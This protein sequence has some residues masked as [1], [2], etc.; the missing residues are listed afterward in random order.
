MSFHPIRYICSGQLGD[1]V[2]A[3][4]V[5]NENYI[6]TGRKGIVYLTERLERFQY[7]FQKTYDALKSILHQQPYI[8][9]FKIYNNE[10]YDVDLSKWRYNITPQSTWYDIYSKTY[11]IE[12]GKNQWLY[13]PMIDKFKDSIIICH[14]IRRLNQKLDYKNFDKLIK[15]T[16]KKIYFITTDTREYLHF[17]KLTNFNCEYI[18]FDS[19]FDCW[20]AIASCYLFIGNMSSPLSVAYACHKNSVGILSA[21]NIDDP[22]FTGLEKISERYQWYQTN[23]LHTSKVPEYLNVNQFA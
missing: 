8:E 16:N 19:L 21:S 20:C 4:S 5:V 12:W 22:F 1:F 9:N 23:Q 6:N 7:G 2:H 14:S 3:L 15:D 17:K 18:L 10:K 13:F 11:S